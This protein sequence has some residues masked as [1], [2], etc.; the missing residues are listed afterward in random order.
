MKRKKTNSFPDSGAAGA[1]PSKFRLRSTLHG[2][3]RSAEPHSDLRVRLD[4][5]LPLAL[6]SCAL[7]TVATMV[8]AAERPSISPREAAALERA[9]EVAETNTARAVE[10]LDEERRRERSSAAL[11]YSAGNLLTEMERNE[12]AIAAYREAVEKFPAFD[13]ARLGWGRALAVQ[14]AWEE[15]ERVLRPVAQRHDATEDVLLLYGF[16]LLELD[17]VISAESIYRRALIAGGESADAM[18][19]LARCFMEQERYREC[20]AI[21]EELVRQRPENATYWALLADVWLAAERPEKAL[22]RLEAAHRLGAA[23]ASML[24]QLGDLYVHQGQGTDAVRAYDAAWSM[25]SD[26]RGLL[27]RLAEGLLYAGATERVGV[28]LDQYDDERTVRYVR[29]RAQWAEAAGE[30][31]QAREAYRE[32][33]QLEPLNERALLALGDLYYD[34]GDYDMAEIWYERARDAHPQRHEA[35]LRLAR[36]ALDREAYDEAANH[37]ERAHVLSGDPEIER[38]LQQVRRVRDVME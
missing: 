8:S 9:A 31:E 3:R 17:R 29:V 36:V 1:S 26:D 30:D 37:L 35:L 19:G 10:I 32:W 20:A 11:D 33:V 7:L 18:Y 2:G 22:V 28:L 5:A 25:R 24:A 4:R 14:E 34:A 16:V 13:E 23:S 38:S 21:M 6:V 15:A 12:E 27:L